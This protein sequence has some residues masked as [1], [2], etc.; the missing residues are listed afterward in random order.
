LEA[1]S[2]SRAGVPDLAHERIDSKI[3][4]FKGVDPMQICQANAK[5]LLW[6]RIFNSKWKNEL[7]SISSYRNLASNIVVIVA[8]IREDQEH[9][10]AGFYCLHNF[11]VKWSARPDVPGCDPTTNTALFQS[12]NDIES[13]WPIFGY[14]ANE[15]GTC[16][17]LRQMFF[18]SIASLRRFNLGLDARAR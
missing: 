16:S 18:R 11:V 13:N 10:L 3:K 4:I 14:V 1:V 15:E 9:R 5:S 12:V 8:L 17:S 6:L 7:T 2:L